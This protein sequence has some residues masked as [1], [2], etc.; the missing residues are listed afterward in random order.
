MNLPVYASS[1]AFIIDTVVT[2]ITLGDF[3]LQ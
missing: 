1:A 3:L 2:A